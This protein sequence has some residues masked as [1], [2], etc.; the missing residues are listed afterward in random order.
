MKK[1][2]AFY[3]LLACLCVGTGCEENPFVDFG[4][5]DIIK[6]GGDNQV[7]LPNSPLDK[8]VRVLV[9]DKN[10]SPVAD[11]GV[12]FTV[13][14]GGGST[15][16]SIYLTDTTGIAEVTWQLGA[17]GSQQLE[18]AAK[19]LEG[20]T[21]SKQELT[22]NAMV[23]DIQQGTFVDNRDGQTYPTTTI[24]GE[25]WL[26]TNLRYGGISHW[27]NTTNP[28]SAYGYLYEWQQAKNACPNG[29]RLADDSDWKYIENVLGMPDGQEVNTGWRGISAGKKLKDTTAWTPL[30]GNNFS[31][32]AA[33]PAGYYESATGN[34]QALGD[35]AYFWT[36]SADTSNSPIEAYY[37]KLAGTEDMVYRAKMDT[38][39]ALS[40]RCVE[41]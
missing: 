7:A 1:T 38:T 27:E 6:W 40:C 29:W 20:N 17:S 15:S 11:V 9:A 10:G 33:L 5:Y 36:A 34:Y 30:A 28:D 14:E 18:V 3:L 39:V 41:D 26:A 35:E 25:R 23:L 24:G 21:I 4:I 12:H 31:A 13:I 19:D 22:F 8:K 16:A 2:V 37:R 32:F